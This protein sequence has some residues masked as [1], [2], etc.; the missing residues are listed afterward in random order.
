M[1]CLTDVCLNET[2]HYSQLCETCQLDKWGSEPLSLLPSCLSDIVVSNLDPINPTDFVTYRNCNT[3]DIRYFLT[4][5]STDKSRI[6][7]LRACWCLDNALRENHDESVDYIMDRFGNSHEFVECY[8]TVKAAVERGS[9]DILNRLQFETQSKLFAAICAS[10]HKNDDVCYWYLKRYVWAYDEALF[11]EFVQRICTL[12]S[13]RCMQRLRGHNAFSDPQMA[14]RILAHCVT[15]HTDLAFFQLVWQQNYKRTYHPSLSIILGLAIEH[16]NLPVLYYLSTLKN[17]TVAHVSKEWTC[18]IYDPDIYRWSEARASLILHDFWLS[19][20]IWFGCSQALNEFL[21]RFIDCMPREAIIT[22][23][24]SPPF[25]PTHQNLIDIIAERQNWT[26][27]FELC[28][29]FDELQDDIQ[30]DCILENAVIAKTHE[31]LERLLN[32]L[33]YIIIQL[34]F[35]FVIRF[36]IVNCDIY[37]INLV[38][39]TLRQ[40]DLWLEQQSTR[41]DMLVL[42]CQTHKIDLIRCVVSCMQDVAFDVFFQFVDNFDYS[43]A[44]HLYIACGWNVATLL[45][46]KPSFLRIATERTT[47][48]EHLRSWIASLHSYAHK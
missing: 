48:L 3:A 10:N 15:S 27:F 22:R 11:F 7:A 29:R 18:A 2:Q 40:F 8:D 34:H 17:F 21:L 12:Q 41:F 33:P 25:R 13:L 6:Q 9:I 43:T 46:H 4:L 44:T 36:T 1:L 24:A 26:L 32:T 5:F 23:L 37:R 16:R 30:W 45:E 35:Q 14:K 47:N 19:D 31:P 39:A 42:A 38:L 28:L 20:D